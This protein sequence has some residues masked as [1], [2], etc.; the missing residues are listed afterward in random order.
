MSGFEAALNLLREQRRTVKD[1]RWDIIRD[2]ALKRED[3][4]HHH[5]LLI[6]T[7]AEQTQLSSAITLLERVEA[8]DAVVVARGDVPGLA[9]ALTQAKNDPLKR[10]APRQHGLV[11]KTVEVAA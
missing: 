6:Q 3:S 9:S 5:Q 2:E 1:V 10:R 7:Q 8:G 4:A 11:R